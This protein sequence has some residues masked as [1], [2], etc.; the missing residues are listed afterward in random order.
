MAAVAGGGMVPGYN[1]K[2]TYD[3]KNYP[4]GG[5]AGVEI[6]RGG[7]LGTVVISKSMAAHPEVM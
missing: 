7:T 3:G 2:L 5:S 6:P 1:A 4:S